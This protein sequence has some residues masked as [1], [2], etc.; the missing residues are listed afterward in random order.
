MIYGKNPAIEMINMAYNRLI[1]NLNCTKMKKLEKLN[2]NPEKVMKV[3]ELL[4]LKGGEIGGPGTCGYNVFAYGHWN[5][6]CG[7]NQETVNRVIQVWGS[8]NVWWCCDSCGS[9]SYCGNY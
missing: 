4:N 3:K 5:A 9:S 8:E 1:V 6:E 2:I 7:V